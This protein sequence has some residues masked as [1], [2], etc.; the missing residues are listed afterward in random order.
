MMND[1]IVNL[2]VKKRHTKEPLKKFGNRLAEIRKQKGFSQED[3]A[4]ESD[5]NRGYLSGVECG[6]RN[7]GLKNIVR[8]ADSLGISAS[9]FFKD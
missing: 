2:N 5:I 6:K 1:N 8:L 4:L 3:L 9:D 7:I